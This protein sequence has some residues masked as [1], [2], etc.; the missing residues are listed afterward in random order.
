M[1]IQN[2]L[3]DLQ[4]RAGAALEDLD[5]DASLD[6]AKDTAYK[7]RERLQSD[8]RAR[9]LTIGGGVLLAGL[10]ATKG[11][12]RLVGNVA[13]TGAVAA[14]GALAYK[15]W[16]DRD[17]SSPPGPDDGGQVQPLDHDL[18][19]LE[20]VEAAGFVIDAQSDPAFARALVHAM[21]TAAYAD[22]A[23][24]PGERTAI[25]GV[26]TTDD[27]DLKALVDNSRS[28]EDCLELIA[29]AARTPNHAAQLY[30]AA[31]IAISEQDPRES[32]FL[33]RLASRL[34]VAP[35]HAEAIAHEVSSA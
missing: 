3:E 30:S 35:A 11:G 19:E 26:V 16:Q 9:N 1:N 22:G 24:D 29:L 20:D 32:R 14:L 6:Q 21:A 13:K 25:D 34:G 18:P 31:V 27:Q 17:R 10:L 15:A 7:V 12:R 23:I 5:V 4:L 33:A 2:L 8:E 28:E